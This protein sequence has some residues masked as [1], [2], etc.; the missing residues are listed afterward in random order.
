MASQARHG[1]Y[2]DEK[3]SKQTGK[4]SAQASK[5]N[6]QPGTK[7]AESL[8]YASEGVGDYDIFKFTVSDWQVLGFITFLGALV[9]LFRIYQPSSVVF[10]EV[11]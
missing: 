11:Q 1:V 10:D 6:E 4:S 3:K 2:L 5:P 7:K 8:T 9:R